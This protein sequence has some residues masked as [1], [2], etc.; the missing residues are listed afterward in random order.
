MCSR[1]GPRPPRSSARSRARRPRWP[2]R[3]DPE[4]KPFRVPGRCP[5]ARGA[6]TAPSRGPPPGLLQQRPC[7]AGRRRSPRRRP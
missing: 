6:P 1:A 2:V 4:A 7:P 3:V 5:H